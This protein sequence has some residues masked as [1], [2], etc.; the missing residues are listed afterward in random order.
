LHDRV[1]EGRAAGGNSANGVRVRQY[2]RSFSVHFIAQLD[3]VS[4]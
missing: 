2:D 3:K 1:L 4:K